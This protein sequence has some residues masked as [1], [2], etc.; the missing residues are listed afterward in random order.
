VAGLAVSLGV[1]LVAAE[2]AGYLLL[3]VVPARVPSYAPFESRADVFWEDLNRDFGVWRRPNV[4]YRHKRSCFD[5]T[6]QSN[7]VGARDPERKLESSKPRVVV[8][9]DSFIEGFGVESGRRLSDILEVRTGA[10]HLNFGTSGF[11]GPTQDLLLYRSLAKPYRHDAVLLGLLPANDF[12]DDDLAFGKI[13]FA[14]RYRPYL[15]GEYPDYRIEYFVDNIDKST[16]RAP[17]VSLQSRLAHFLAETSYAYNVYRSYRDFRPLRIDATDTSWVRKS[18]YYEFHEDG[19]QRLRYV[20]EEIVKEAEG[21]PVTLL[22][23]PI[24]DDLE[25]F[26]DK[27]EAPLSRRLDDMSREIGFRLVDLLPEFAADEAKW[28]TYYL[29]CDGH[30]SAEGNA[31]AARVLLDRGLP[32]SAS[33]PGDRRA[34]AVDA[35]E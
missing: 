13:V 32:W 22:A 31:A 4:T 23:M 5:V 7:S 8:L 12:D 28:P 27:G 34:E 1:F 29:S 25:A 19:M 24:R 15:V 10:E 35:G 2:V 26:R 16:Y 6:Y 11:F 14:N 33:A 20:L 21:R 30:L 9:G 18:H 17:P 3:G